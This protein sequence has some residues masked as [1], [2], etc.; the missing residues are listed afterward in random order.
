MELVRQACAQAVQ[1]RDDLDWKST[2]PLTLPAG[3]EPGRDA[4]QDELAKD[5]A[6]MANSR[7]G[8]IIYGVAETRGANAASH[9][10]S[11][12]E[13]DETTLQNIRR[14]ASNLIYPPVTTLALRWLTSQ[15]S[16]DVALALEVGAE[17]RSAASG[18]AQKTAFWVR[19]LVRGAFPQPA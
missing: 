17:R 13:P 5:I 19:L 9:I 4:Q 6:A 15:E 3:K 1:E 14:V 10:E 18:P 16:E 7:G 11:V 2:L 8:L 12:G